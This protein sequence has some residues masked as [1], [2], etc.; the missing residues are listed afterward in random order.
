MIEIKQV[1]K[2]FEEI[3]AVK[4]IN[5]TIQ[6][7]NVFGMLGTNGA[8]KSTLLRMIAG[9]LKPDEG[10]IFIDGVG[11]WDNPEAKKLCFY[12][13]DEQFFYPNATAADMDRFYSKYY[14]TFDSLRYREMLKIFGFDSKRKIQTYSKGMKKQLSIILGLCTNVPYLLCDETFD[15]LDPV[16]RQGI[17]SIFVKEMGKRS[18]T[19]LIASHN[20]RE[21]E[22]ICDHIGLLHKGG[23]LL[24][25]ELADLKCNLHKIQCVP[26]ENMEK[27]VQ[28]FLDVLKFE[29]RG[30][31][32][33]MTV[34]GDK[35]EILRKMEEWN[36]VYF[37]ALP[38]SLEEI[39]ISE[40]EVTG[41]DIKNLIV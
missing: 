39:F 12:I 4:Q 41:Y 15:G 38:L 27:P 32:I 36:P 29:K 13:S 33:S 28:Q 37:E 26:A 19:L 24:S 40:T 6:P 31:L 23:V 11:V 3:E 18:L 2:A 17:K 1:S 5:L 7:G 10:E 14:L 16:M 22:D 34:R 9:V 8:G 35:E 25:R 21:L 30:R 20:L